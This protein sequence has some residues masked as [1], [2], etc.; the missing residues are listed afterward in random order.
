VLRHSAMAVLTLLRDTEKSMG[1]IAKAVSQDAA[2]S[3]AVLRQANSPAAGLRRAVPNIQ[4]AVSLLGRAT[5]ESIVVSEMVRDAVPAQ[6]VPGF[7]PQRFWAAAARR[8]SIARELAGILDPGNAMIAA[9]ASLLQDIAVPL[10]VHR[11]NERYAPVLQR[12]HGDGGDLSKQER[13][14]FGWDHSN[15]GEWLCKAW[16][17]PAEL[18]ELIGAHHSPDSSSASVAIVAALGEEP[19]DDDIDRL[20]AL[21]KQRY[22]TPPEVI[23]RALRLAG[24]SE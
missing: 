20:M 1:Q 3:V 14:T 15:V 8:S 16:Q 6:A 10:L 12:W 4:H 24:N 11:Q 13:E 22:N 9:T 21:G 17:L 19:S 23:L 18:T 2:L 7:Q 5:L